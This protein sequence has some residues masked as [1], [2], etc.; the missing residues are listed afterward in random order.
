MN[1]CTAGNEKSLVSLVFLSS[2]QICSEP[3]IERYARAVSLK[4]PPLEAL[5]ECRAGAHLLERPRRI[6]SDGGLCAHGS[7]EAERRQPVVPLHTDRG[8]EAEPSVPADLHVGRGHDRVKLNRR[9][10]FSDR[11]SLYRTDTPRPPDRVSAIRFAPGSGEARRQLPRQL[12]SDS[13]WCDKFEPR[14]PYKPSGTNRV[15]HDDPAGPVPSDPADGPDE[16]SRA[17]LQ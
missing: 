6:D 11:S 2:C 5:V 17:P 12:G 3:S 13:T 7:S 15:E 14:V 1:T 4:R 10:F 16:F 8:S 9:N